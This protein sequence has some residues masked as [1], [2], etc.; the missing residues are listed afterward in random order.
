MIKSLFVAAYTGAYIGCSA[1]AIAIHGEEKIADYFAAEFE[2]EWK[3]IKSQ[4]H[5]KRIHYLVVRYFDHPVGFVSCELNPKSGRIYLRWVT[6][7]P[8]CQ[9]QGI[10]EKMLNAVI[11]HFP[12]NLGIELYTRV[13]NT[14]S[15]TFYRRFGCTPVK[16]INFLEP[17]DKKLIPHFMN[18][19]L[20]LSNKK[21]VLYPP[22]DEAFRPQKILKH[23]SGSPKKF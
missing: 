16:K 8:L 20:I 23:L 11:K 19:W 4:N 5:D 17:D 14:G 18:Q 10:G 22:K 13:A 21:N 2:Q 15:Q 6:V 9:R 7:S 3:T 1:K 12:D